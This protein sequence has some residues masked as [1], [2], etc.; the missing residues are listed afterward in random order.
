METIIKKA[1]NQFMK[2]KQSEKILIILVL[3]ILLSGFLFS[4]G[5][6]IGKALYKIIH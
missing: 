5:F 4:S 3:S 2:L 1:Q 6:T